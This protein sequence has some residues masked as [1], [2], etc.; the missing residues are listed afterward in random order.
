MKG[1]TKVLLSTLMTLM[2]RYLLSIALCKRLCTGSYK[3]CFPANMNE[4]QKILEKLFSA[5][6][7]TIL[8]IKLELTFYFIPE[9]AWI[10]FLLYSWNLL[11]TGWSSNFTLKKQKITSE[12]NFYHART[13]C[14]QIS[15]WSDNMIY[16]LSCNHR[17]HVACR[18]LMSQWGEIIS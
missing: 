17:S 4:L 18:I 10:I 5:W 8:H 16:L 1:S 3:K 2:Y 7:G 9:I 15:F 13:I 6:A 11:E 12:T 14:K